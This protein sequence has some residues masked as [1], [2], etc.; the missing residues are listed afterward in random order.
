MCTYLFDV[1][2]PLG[3]G[4]QMALDH[5]IFLGFKMKPAGL[6]R[7][8]FQIFLL[9]KFHFPHSFLY[10]TTYTKNRINNAV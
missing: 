9:T 4:D 1:V 6:I 10:Q 7:G 3:V 2:T 8:I 5:S